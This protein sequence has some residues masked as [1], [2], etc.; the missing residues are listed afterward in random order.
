MQK[1]IGIYGASGFG[2][3]V[4]PLVREQYPESELVFIDDSDTEQEL[5]SYPI[6]TYQTFLSL[7]EKIKGWFCY[8]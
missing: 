3:E 5:N 8:C 2:R 7:P 1:V 4:L 6:Y